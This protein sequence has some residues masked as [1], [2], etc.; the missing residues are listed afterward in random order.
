[1]TPATGASRSAHCGVL[2]LLVAAVRVPRRPGGRPA[3]TGHLRGRR[4]DRGGRRL[5]S[6]N[7][8]DVTGAFS[9]ERDRLS[10]N[11]SLE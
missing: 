4:D 7:Q 8:L 11:R 1:M 5:E 3:L 6:R 9:R 2:N 10:E